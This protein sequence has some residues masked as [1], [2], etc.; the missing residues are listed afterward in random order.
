MLSCILTI[1]K[2]EHE[3][4][5]EWI[6]Y[7]LNLGVNHI[8]IFEDIDSK[9]HKNII[10]KYDNYVSLNNILSI[11][12]EIDKNKVK[13]TKLSKKFNLQHL[14]FRNALIYIKEHYNYDWCFIIDVDEFITID[15]KYKNV[16]E[17]LSLY[18]DYNAFIMHWKCFGA[19][20]YIKK[21][22]YTYKGIIET[23]INEIQGKVPDKLDSLIKTCYNLKTYNN[24]FFYNQH[25]PNKLCKCCNTNGNKNLHKIIYDNIYI[26]HYITK[27]WEEYVWKKTIRGFIWGGFRSLNTFFD[28]NPDMNIYK[29]ELIKDAEKISNIT[30]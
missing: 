12:N 6:N 24:C 21:P 26:R 7:H 10:D 27:S 5:D 28:I 1:I 20:G 11:L 22:D 8:F 2:D 17:V 29:N 4:L 16:N 14:Y 19:N 23:Y 25:H 30:I 13:E 9:S 18:N 3:Y 15:N